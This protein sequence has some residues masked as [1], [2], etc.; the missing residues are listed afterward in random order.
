MP[1]MLIVALRSYFTA[2][3]DASTIAGTRVNLGT[4][5]YQE[6]DSNQIPTG[7]IIPHPSVP[8]KDIEFTFASADPSFDDCFVLPS[9]TD[10]SDF[11][12]VASSVPLDTR[13]LPLRKLCILSHPE[14]GLNLEIR[15]TEPAFQ[16]Y[17]GDG[18]DVEELERPDGTKVPAMGARKGIAIEPSR[19]VNC[20]GR[21]EWRGMCTL[22]KGDVWGARSIY[23]AWKD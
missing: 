16:F 3:P 21:Q 14:S 12:S 4:N 2:N 5:H 23:R 19:F 10:P 20:A 1:R 6:L 11:A 13:P 18:I 15:S 7:K 9:R 17:T 22:K 8:G